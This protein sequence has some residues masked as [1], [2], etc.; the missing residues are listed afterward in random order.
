VCMMAA[1]MSPLVVMA[2]V[3]L[4]RPQVFDKKPTATAEAKDAK[5]NP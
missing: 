5:T 2:V 3:A 4:V 1:I